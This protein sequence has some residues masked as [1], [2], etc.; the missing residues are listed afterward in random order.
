MKYE[1]S[2]THVPTGKSFNSK[3]TELTDEELD[4][5]KVL[6][7]SC[8]SDKVLYLTIETCMGPTTIGKNLLPD[9]T[10]TISEYKQ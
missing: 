7:Q 9:C 10:F 5:I 6:F 1:Y 4:R 8:A 2:V 3:S